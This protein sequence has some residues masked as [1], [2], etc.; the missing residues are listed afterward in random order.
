[1]KKKIVTLLIVTLFCPFGAA[2]AVKV[3]DLKH[4]A[5]AVNFAHSGAKFT[6]ENKSSAASANGSTELKGTTLF[7]E[8][9]LTRGFSVGLTFSTFLERSMDVDVGSDK[10]AVVETVTMYSI[11]FKSYLSEHK[12][13]GWKPYFGVGFGSYNVSS[14]IKT[15]SGGTT[16]EGSSSAT[17]PLTIFSLGADYVF[18]FG[19]VRID[20]A[21]TTG[22]REDTDGHSTYNADYNYTG[23]SLG[24]AVFSFF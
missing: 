19:G 5:G 20:Y 12:R 16:T 13:K 11:D 15:T 21:L 3:A 7:Y 1:M 8:R 24:I 18:S 17:V 9:L 6:L 14:T 22:K 10:N 23:T 4:K 2:F